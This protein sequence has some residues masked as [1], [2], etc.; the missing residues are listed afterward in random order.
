MKDIY[1]QLLEDIRLT[2]WCA[3][4]SGYDAYVCTSCAKYVR[5]LYPQNTKIIGFASW[6]NPEALLSRAQ[7]GHDFAIIE[8]R[9][10]VDIWAVDI[11]SAS[12]HKVLD[13]RNPTHQEI[14]L[15]LYGDKAAWFE[16]VSNNWISYEQEAR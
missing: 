2:A 9:Y 13:L 6:D 5:S 4:L 14:I 12:L 3:S 8:D 11:E 16:L 15:S 7:D 10:I 1:Y